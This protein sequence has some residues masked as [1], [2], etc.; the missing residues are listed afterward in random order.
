LPDQLVLLASTAT[1]AIA[2]ER[3]TLARAVEGD[4]R[5][6]NRREREDRQRAREQFLRLRH[7]S[8]LP[9]LE[10]LRIRLERLGVHSRRPTAAPTGG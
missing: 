9:S 2:K 4:T 5:G 7:L 3:D 6:R 1:G 8:H 10:P